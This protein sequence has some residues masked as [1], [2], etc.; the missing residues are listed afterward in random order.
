LQ[1]NHALFLYCLDTLKVCTREVYERKVRF[2]TS[3]VLASMRLP[4]AR[5]TGYSPPI[6]WA[7][8]FKQAWP[9]HINPCP[10][11]R[12]PDTKLFSFSR[13]TCLPTRIAPSFFRRFP[14]P[15]SSFPFPLGPLPFAAS[16]IISFSSPFTI[17]LTSTSVSFPR[18]LEAYTRA[19]T[20][21]QIGL[22]G[23]LPN[24]HLNHRLIH[25]KWPLGPQDI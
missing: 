25:P 14:F 12:R 18:S 11:A 4:E 9:G 7:S 8:Y 23:D 5:P 3:T 15:L 17:A 13:A 21:R 19:R 6:P 2:S 1:K 16:F 20:P 10:K 22:W 24:F